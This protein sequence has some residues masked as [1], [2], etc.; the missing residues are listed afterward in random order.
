MGEIIRHLNEAVFQFLIGRLQTTE[1]L[2]ALIYPD[3]FQ[4]LI[5]RFQ[6]CPNR[7]A[8]AKLLNVSIPY[9]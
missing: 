4:F 9:R 7:E 8:R 5:G 3:E 6:T 1:S 2:D